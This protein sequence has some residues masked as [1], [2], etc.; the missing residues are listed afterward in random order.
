MGKL[1][2]WRMDVHSIKPGR[3]VNTSDVINATELQVATD[4]LWAEAQIQD[5][6]FPRVW[7]GTVDSVGS[8]ACPASGSVTVFFGN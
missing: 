1:S 5:R 8:K 2:K 3:Q 6:K 7:P 4:F